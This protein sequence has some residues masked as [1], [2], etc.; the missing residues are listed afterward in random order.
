M[1]GGSVETS[2]KM[3]TNRAARFVVILALACAVAL[4]I[5]Q[6]AKLLFIFYAR[7][8]YPFDLEWME[9]GMLTHA[10]R[11]LQG[12]PLYGPPSVDFIAHLYTPLYPL[13]LAGLAE[14]FGLSYTLGRV[15]SIVSFLIGLGLT[16]AIVYRETQRG[17]RGLAFAVITMGLI[18][19]SFPRTGAWF[20]LVRN[21]S[22]NL[23]LIVLSL[24][25]WLY[26]APGWRRPLVVGV[27]LS[28]AFLAKQIAAPLILLFGAFCLVKRRRELLILVAVVTLFVGGVLVGLSFVSDGWS[29]RYIFELHQG[30]TTSW[31][32]F[33]NAFRKIGLDAWPLILL[34]SGWLAT[35]VLSA[36]RWEFLRASRRGRYLLAFSCMGVLISAIGYATEWADANAFIVANVVIPLAAV[37]CTHDLIQRAGR[38]YGSCFTAIGLIGAAIVFGWSLNR[39]SYSAEKYIPKPSD[40]TN[41]ERLIATIKQ[42]A[43]P[44]LIPYHPY[45]AHLAGKPSHYHQMGINDVTRAGYPLPSDLRQR[46]EQ[47]HYQ[48]IVLD[49]RPSGRY[50]FIQ[51]YYRLDQ[52]IPRNQAPKVFT[53]FAVSPQYHFVPRPH[54]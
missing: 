36:P 43:G 13:I 22:L 23:A 28:L 34:L 48:L 20:D 26:M 1:L 8:S 18:A 49:R 54:P 7:S 12:D 3:K 30:H 6:I 25:C 17:L 2:T 27:C 29:W 44:V 15:V 10:L 45:Y 37:L 40:W 21:D 11:I 14:V 39:Q 5:G 9:G 24:F 47:K 33:V 52:T 50:G 46:I 4:A 35:T 53:G 31:T 41:G 38:R 51:R 42:T 16:G 19:G 32:R